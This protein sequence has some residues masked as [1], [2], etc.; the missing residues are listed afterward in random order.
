MGQYGRG[1]L[2]AS[3]AA[4]QRV[5]VGQQK[6]GGLLGT[7][8]VALVEGFHHLGNVAAEDGRA[9]LRLPVPAG[10][11]A[12]PTCMAKSCSASTTGCAAAS[13]WSL[14]P[15]EGRARAG[16]CGAGGDWRRAAA[17]LRVSDERHFNHPKIFCRSWLM[18]RLEVGSLF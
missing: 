12:Q 9:Q 7:G 4:E 3:S 17:A 16:G 6:A 8:P 14:A 2:C 15:G 5:E 18:P 13:R 1:I 11:S 10:D